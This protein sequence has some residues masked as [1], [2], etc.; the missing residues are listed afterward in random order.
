[1]GIME[2]NFSNTYSSSRLSA[3]DAQVLLAD[4]ITHLEQHRYYLKEDYKIGQLSIETNISS[5]HISELLNKYYKKSFSDVING[6]RIEEAKKLLV[7]KNYRH[8]KVSSVGFDVGFK[9]P[10]TF[11]TWFKKITGTSPA[12]YQ[13]ENSR[14]PENTIEL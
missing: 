1:M 2:K 10:S 8:K 14:F 13:K 5:H 4:L 6:Y 11:Y 9:S 3:D 7:S 12:N